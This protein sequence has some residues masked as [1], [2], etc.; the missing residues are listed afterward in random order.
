MK[1]IYCSLLFIALVSV[2]S[3]QQPKIKVQGKKL[4]DETGDCFL[5]FGYNYLGNI[6]WG[7]IDD[8]WQTDSTWATTASDFDEMK[9]YGANTVRIHLQYNKMMNSI[10]EANPAAILRLQQLVHLAEEK[11]VYILL[12]GLGAYR[13][14]DQPIWYD[15]LS[16]ENRWAAQATFW[17]KIAQAVGSSKAIYAYDLINEPVSQKTTTW[18][19][20]EPL[21]SLYFV[22]SLTKNPKGRSFD[23]IIIPWIQQMKT[24]IRQYD[25]QTLITCGFLPCGFIKDWSIDLDFVSTHIYPHPIDGDPQPCSGNLQQDIDFVTINQSD[26]P[27]VLSEFGVWTTF[28]S[29]NPFMDAVCNMVNGWVCHYNGKT[30]D[31]LLRDNSIKDAV[32][33][34][35]LK[36]FK[37]KYPDFHVCQPACGGAVTHKEPAEKDADLKAAYNFNN[38]SDDKTGNKYNG[39]NFNMKYSAGSTGG[40]LTAAWFSPDTKSYIRLPD[41]A[42]MRFSYDQSFTILATVYPWYKTAGSVICY[43]DKDNADNDNP[44]VRDVVRLSVKA[45]DIN[46]FR[47]VFEYGTDNSTAAQTERLISAPCSF[48]N[49]YQIV[50]MYNTGNDSSY[51][52]VNGVAVDSIAHAL[53]NTWSAKGQYIMMGRNNFQNGINS[54]YFN[55][56]I[57][58]LKIYKRAFAKVETATPFGINV[59]PDIT[60][61]AIKKEDGVI[62]VVKSEYR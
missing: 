12:T 53:T 55:G 15:T 10:T 1:K 43:D 34:E 62:K 44:S 42:D 30:I 26:K 37:R 18:T 33:L 6:Q 47:F 25:A 27:F 49:W 19:V 52:F 14:G 4:I 56:K 38:N 29:L 50:A 20:G 22:Q 2:A 8:Y 16:E 61:V 60:P 28:E 11:R 24:A 57:D 39:T 41:T 35:Q 13:R 9:L 5:P 21:D 3:A 58:F 36:I 40:T 32:Q 51:L 45:I 23:Q 17:G 46:S 54:G 31:D 48:N 7:L 59:L